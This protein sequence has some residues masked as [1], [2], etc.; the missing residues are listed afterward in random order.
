M[1]ANDVTA[2]SMIA[3]WLVMVSLNWHACETQQLALKSDT[4][5]RLGSCMKE[6]VIM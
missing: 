3:Q 2:Y 5:I 6:R 1:H 4:G